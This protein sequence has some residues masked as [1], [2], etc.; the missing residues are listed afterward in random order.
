M[1]TVFVVFMSPVLP[2]IVWGCYH[3]YGNMKTSGE[4]S[5]GFDDRH[6]TCVAYTVLLINQWTNESLDVFS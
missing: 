3:F 4:H 1:K 5:L 6:I 2:C